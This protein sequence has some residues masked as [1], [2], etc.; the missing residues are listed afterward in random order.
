MRQDVEVELPGSIGHQR[1]TLSSW[2]F[3]PGDKPLLLSCEC[4]WKKWVEDSLENTKYAF[5]EDHKESSRRLEE[6]ATKTDEQVMQLLEKMASS[7]SVRGRELLQEAARRLQFRNRVS[8]LSPD[9]EYI[10]SSIEGSTV[11]AWPAMT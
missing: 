10:S 8:I 2:D 7:S 9:T 4:G 3:E 1:G 6:L 11:G 5:V